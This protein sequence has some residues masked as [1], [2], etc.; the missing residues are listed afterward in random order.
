MHTYISYGCCHMHAHALLLLYTWISFRAVVL[1][2]MYKSNTRRRRTW[3]RRLR[4]VLNSPC[5]QTILYFGMYVC[6]FA[7]YS[8]HKITYST[9]FPTN[10]YRRIDISVAKRVT[11][12]L[13]R[14]L[15]CL[16]CAIH[17]VESS[18]STWSY[19]YIFLCCQKALDRRHLIYHTYFFYVVKKLSID[20]ILY[21]FFYVVKSSR[22]TSSYIYIYISM[23][24][25]SSRSTSSYI[26]IYIFYV[27]E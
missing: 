17:V 23:L 22:S 21:I 13:P 11:M 15:V 1:N 5:P 8:W 4:F 16:C 3:V 9:P 14:V 27:V 24:L 25:K 12:P 20:I 7:I 26:Y 2:A 19:M 10:L 6:M 18:R